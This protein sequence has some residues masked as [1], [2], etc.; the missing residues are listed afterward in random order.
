MNVLNITVKHEVFG[1]GRITEQ[2][3]DIIT[4]T[5]PKPYGKRKFLYPNAFLQHL[6][7]CDASLTPEMEQELR[8]HRQQIVT[9]QNRMNRAEKIA[10]LQES[11][12]AKTKRSNSK[13]TK[14][15]NA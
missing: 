1:I 13:K 7:L 14:K 3:E 6:T 15:T 4:I 5:F 12:A 10:R 9:E 2:E 11:S 8:S